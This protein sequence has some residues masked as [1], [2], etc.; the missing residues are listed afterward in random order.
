VRGLMRELLARCGL[1]TKQVIAIGMGV[2]GPVDF[3]S[4]QLVQPAADPRLGRLFDP[5]LPARGVCR[6][7][8]CGQR[9]EPDCAGRDVPAAA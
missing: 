8:V 1:A 5:R 7:G 3:E 4:G 6:A 2:P 9:L